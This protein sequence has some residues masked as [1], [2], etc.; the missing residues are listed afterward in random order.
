MLYKKFKLLDIASCSAQDQLISRTSHARQDFKPGLLIQLIY[1]PKSDTHVRI[2]ITQELKGITKSPNQSFLE[3]RNI[4]FP[5]NYL[6]LLI[7]SIKRL[8]L[9]KRK[10]RNAWVCEDYI[11]WQRP[12]GRSEASWTSLPSSSLS[13]WTTVAPPLSPLTALTLLHK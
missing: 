3:N 9:Y 12:I 11:P 5:E 2:H 7:S 13:S 10:K 6:H 4:S 1:Y 8:R